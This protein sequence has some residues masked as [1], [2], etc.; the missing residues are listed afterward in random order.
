MAIQWTGAG[1][2][3]VMEGGSHTR[4]LSDCAPLCPV[5]VGRPA[6]TTGRGGRR[7]LAEIPP[8]MTPR[9]LLTAAVLFGA[10]LLVCALGGAGAQQ[11]QPQ[12]PPGPPDRHGD[13]LPSPAALQRLGTV[14]FRH[15]DKILCVAFSPDGKRI[16]AGGGT[17]PVRLWDAAT[18]KQLGQ[19]KDIWAL[20]L[21][22]S[23]DG[24]LLATGGGYK[25]VRVW[26]VETGKVRFV[27]K[28]HLA[29][30]KALAF[31]PDGTLLASGSQD[32]TV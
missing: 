18:G 28:G 26:D 19:F 25:T 23:P 29:S 2:G 24:K 17:D 31:S 14:R 16:A 32:R 30:V 5:P 8:V 6:S 13:P 27:F 1:G 21:A 10:G 4:F 15:G 22:F 12:P 3:F 11:P 20:A 7:P 9:K